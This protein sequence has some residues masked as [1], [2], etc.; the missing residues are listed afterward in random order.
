MRQEMGL[1]QLKSH[2]F[3]NFDD[4]I[5]KTAGFYIASLDNRPVTRGRSPLE[6]FSPPWKNMFESIGHS[7]K[8]LCQSQKT[9]RPSCC[10]K[11]VTGLLDNMS[12]IR[13]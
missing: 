9:L 1:D 10:P 6:I 2:E 11:L 8:N 7:L 5:R 13:S 3:L 4:M 12:M